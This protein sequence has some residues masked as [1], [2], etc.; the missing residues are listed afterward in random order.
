LR[1]AAWVPGAVPQISEDGLAVDLVPAGAQF[2]R[3]VLIVGKVTWGATSADLDNVELYLPNTNLELGPVV[4]TVSATI[5]Q[6]AL[7][8]ITLGGPSS[9]VGVCQHVDEIR[10]GA[11]YTAVIGDPAPP[12]AALGTPHSW[13]Q[14]FGITN[15]YD[16][17][18]L[19]DP[20][21]DGSPTW[22]EYQAGTN[23]NDP[24]SAFKISSI[25]KTGADIELVWQGTTNSGLT[26]DFIIYRSTNLTNWIE[27]GRVARSPSG[28]NIWVG[29]VVPGTE[30]AFYRIGVAQ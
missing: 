15:N 10:F 2:D 23:P 17:A 29:T 13:L 9:N 18:E 16:A 24:N 21:H 3:T 5:D 27:V 14:S 25:S 4:T 1:A 8:T 26:T 20:D 6:S 28:T 7:D 12:T 11:N 30:P 19:A 22:E